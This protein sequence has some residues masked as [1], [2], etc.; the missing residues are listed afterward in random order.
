MTRSINTFGFWF[1]HFLCIFLRRDNRESAIDSWAPVSK[2]QSFLSN[3][4]Y[5]MTSIFQ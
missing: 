4:K 3:T 1:L 2:V 5:A